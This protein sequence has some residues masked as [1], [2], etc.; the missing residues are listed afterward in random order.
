MIRFSRV[1]DHLYQ[2]EIT[3]F[4]LEK[5]PLRNIFACLFSIHNIIS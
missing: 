2:P 3:I 1:L 5:I 4:V